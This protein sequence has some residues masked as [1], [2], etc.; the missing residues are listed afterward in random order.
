MAWQ[1]VGITSPTVLRNFIHDIPIIRHDSQCLLIYCNT[2]TLRFAYAWNVNLSPPVYKEQTCLHQS[3]GQTVVRLM[4]RSK[5]VLLFVVKIAANVCVN[6][7]T[8][9]LTQ[10]NQLVCIIRTRSRLWVSSICT[11]F[12]A[13]TMTQRPYTTGQL[14][15]GVDRFGQRLGVVIAGWLDADANAA[16]RAYADTICGMTLVSWCR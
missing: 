3:R 9:T 6:D 16:S 1:I 13:E 8:S 4:F 15:M 2:W 10:I 11:C 14:K 7:N 12:G 5:L